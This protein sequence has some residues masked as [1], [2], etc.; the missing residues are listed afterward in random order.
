MDHSGM[1][2][3]DLFYDYRKGRAAFLDAA[4]KTGRDT[5]TRVHPDSVG[6]DGKPLFLDTVWLGQR[7]A[8][9]A[10]LVIG[11][12][13]GVDGAFGAFVLTG[14]LQEKGFQAPPDTKI[15]LLN[16][17]NPFGYAWSRLVDD[18]NIDIDHNFIDFDQPPANPAYLKLATHFD[19]RFA[20]QPPLPADEVLEVLARG[21]YS[22]PAGLA[23]GGADISWSQRMLGDVVREELRQVEELIVLDLQTGP[24]ALGDVTLS[25][26]VGARAGQVWGRIRA[27]PDYGSVTAGIGDWCGA[28]AASLCVGAIAPENYL[29]LICR[30]QWLWGQGRPNHPQAEEIAA[31]MQAAFFPA[32]EDWRRRARAAVHSTLAAALVRLAG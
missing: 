20:T 22:H 26:P 24:G 27:V 6:R 12:T 15:V 19:G 30:D 10:L 17:L 18:A 31:E 8:R 4:G 2:E 5:I 13:H 3:A 9:K 16:A 23:Y 25:A 11:G 14:L 28:A 21:Q 7:D 32:D 1:R 29:N